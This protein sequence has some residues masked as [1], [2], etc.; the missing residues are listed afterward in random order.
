MDLQQLLGPVGPLGAALGVGVVE[1]EDRVTEPGKSIAE[2]DHERVI[3]VGPRTMGEQ[4]TNPARP[5]KTAGNGPA[6][7]RDGHRLGHR[8]G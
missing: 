4:H 8:S 1:R 6:V 7:V 3:L 2:P 5:G